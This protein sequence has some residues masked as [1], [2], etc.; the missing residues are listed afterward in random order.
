MYIHDTEQLRDLFTLWYIFLPIVAIM[1]FT[2]VQTYK[3]H[4]Q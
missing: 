3:S 1:Q 4:L 2:N